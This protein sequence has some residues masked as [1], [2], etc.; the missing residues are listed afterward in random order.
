MKKAKIFLSAI[1]ILAV[2]GGALA[3]KAQRLSQL[4]WV[5]TIT[6]ETEDGAL[7]RCTQHEYFTQPP[8]NTVL[9]VNFR[10][11]TY[12]SIVNGVTYLYCT[13]ATLKTYISTQEAS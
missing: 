9:P 12:T 1:A 3:F 7:I 11:G 2:I 8:T 4:Y 10:T 6:T 13:T 5:T